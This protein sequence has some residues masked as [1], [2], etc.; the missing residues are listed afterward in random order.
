MHGRHPRVGRQPKRRH[1]TSVTCKVWTMSATTIQRTPVR[2]SDI[3][4]Q[5]LTGER[6][7]T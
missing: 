4:G 7:L 3:L 2:P 5:V 1:F 6:A